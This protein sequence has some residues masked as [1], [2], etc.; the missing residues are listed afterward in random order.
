M[1][2]LSNIDRLP[3]GTGSTEDRLHQNVDLLLREG[4]IQGLEAHSA[5][6]HAAQG[7]PDHQWVDCSGLTLTPELVDCHGHVTVLGI[8]DEHM[9]SMQGASELLYVEK[10]LYSS[11]VNGG[12]TSM[13]DVGGSTDLMKR[14]VEMAFE[15][16][17][18]VTPTSWVVHELLKAEGLFDFVMDKVQRV[19]ELHAEAVSFAAS[20][21]LPILMGT[22]PVLPGMHGPNFMELVY[23]IR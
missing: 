6:R 13:R 9:Q 12:V 4:V 19:A 5:E 11:L 21:E 1:L 14:L 10:I 2:I 18:S 7:G 16:G 22:D 17:C 23:L 3:D 15:R 8:S 20:G